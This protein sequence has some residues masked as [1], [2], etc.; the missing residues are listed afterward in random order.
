MTLKWRAFDALMNKRESRMSERAGRR[1]AGGRVGRRE[2]RANAG[3]ASAPFIQ[4]KIPYVEILSEEGLQ[5]IEDIAAR[6][7]EEVGIDFLDDPAVLELS[8]TACARVDG[9][10]GRFPQRMCREIIHATAPSEY[11]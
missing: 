7:R 11:D 3:P 2:A 1:K 4:R 10:H 5:L 9:T 8:R 6:L